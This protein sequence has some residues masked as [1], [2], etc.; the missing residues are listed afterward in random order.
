MAGNTKII[1]TGLEAGREAGQPLRYVKLLRE[2]YLNGALLPAGA[3]TV[4]PQGV[5]VLGN[6]LVEWDTS[7]DSPVE[8]KKQPPADT[9]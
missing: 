9:K 2:S 3:V 4:W 1:S 5:E 8:A 6:N 7:T